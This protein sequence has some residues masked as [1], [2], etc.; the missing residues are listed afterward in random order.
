MDPRGN[1]N[2]GTWGFL[3]SLQKL[4]KMFNPDEIVVCW[5]GVGGSEKKR[6]INKN[7]K[8]GRKPL[9]FNRRMIDLTPEAQEKNKA[10]QQVR[11]MGY[12]NDMPIIQTM[13][14]FLL[15]LNL[16]SILEHQK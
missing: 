1:P 2:G 4:C 5:D 8:Q 7:Y 9:R 10:Y 16:F 14:D 6:T 15:V 3:K 11:L 12:L 13:I